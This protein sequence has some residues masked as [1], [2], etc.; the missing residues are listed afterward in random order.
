MASASIFATAVD[1]D[2]L[3]PG[4]EHGGW[5]AT[6]FGGRDTV[7]ITAFA[8]RTHIEGEHMTSFSRVLVVENVSIETRSV[9]GNITYFVW[10]SVRNAGNQFIPVYTIN[11]AKVSP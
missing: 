3:A 9:G 4:Q 8:A 5:W 1:T 6:G 10:C 7:L 2:G 11:W